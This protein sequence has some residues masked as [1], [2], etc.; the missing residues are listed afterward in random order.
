MPSCGLL[1]GYALFVKVTKIL[2]QKIQHSVAD[3]KDRFQLFLTPPLLNKV[4]SRCPL[5]AAVAEKGLIG[6]FNSANPGKNKTWLR[7]KRFE[8]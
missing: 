8:T 3:E 4:L 5:T 7:K 6:A 2:G 1:S